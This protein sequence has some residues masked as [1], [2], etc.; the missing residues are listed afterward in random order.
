MAE[1]EKSNAPK[2]TTYLERRVE[3]L[4]NVLK[5]ERLILDY[6]ANVELR[7]EL[8]RDLYNI[9]RH[10][11]GRINLET[12]TPLVR[13][14]A[15]TQYAL[16]DVYLEGNG[17]SQQQQETT[18]VA[19]AAPLNPFDSQREYFA[20]LSS[21][22]KRLTGK[23]RP[24]QFATPETFFE[25]MKKNGETLSRNHDAAFAYLEES[26][27]RFYQTNWRTMPESARNLG[28]LKFILG[29]GQRFPATAGN[30]VRSMLLYA[31]TILISDPVLPWIEMSRKEEKF[32]SIW[33]LSQIFQILFLKPFVDADLAYPPVLVVP[34]FDR[35]MALESEETKD[36]ISQ[37]DLS[38]FSTYFG[39][40]FEDES[41]IFEFAASEPEF[42]RIVEKDKLFYP[43]NAGYI[44]ETAA[45]AAQIY[46]DYLTQYRNEPYLTNA[47]TW[48]D[49]PLI[50]Q[51]IRER[52]EPQFH[53]RE[54][55]DW[56]NAQP[57][58]WN[59]A[60]WHYF[61]LCAGVSEE[62]LREEGVVSN[63]TIASARALN[64]PG[65]QWLGNIPL[66]ALVELRKRNENETFRRRLHEFTSALHESN[67]GDI[68]RVAAE[69]SRGIS[70]LIADHQSAMRRIEEKYAPKYRL[71]AGLSWLTL[72]GTFLPWLAPTLSQ[73]I[74]DM[75]RGAGL[76]AAGPMAYRYLMDKREER[77]ERKQASNSLVGVLATAQHRRAKE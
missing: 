4:L 16:K 57:L 18:S 14:I 30:A 28:G 40:R 6:I 64:S 77:A 49:G 20:I 24:A 72:I 53:L 26:L 66:K 50:V 31:D 37:L 63:E 60:H 22:F 70:S 51:G 67:L 68:N 7:N 9:Q 62:R 74:P 35:R 71:Q 19:I 43:P 44:P 75:P 29:A 61:K 11:N 13:S 73:I 42:L 12:C 52:L 69:V 46:R 76:V 58:L 8:A 48:G 56:L 17:E 36:G 38:F 65:L 27:S 5:E 54:N 15:R 33:L 10:P 41:E 23:R 34:T 21:F 25:E 47:R 39:T 32:P 55:V 3:H 59:D 1:A 2:P 45:E